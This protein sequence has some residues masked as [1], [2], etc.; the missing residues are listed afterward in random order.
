MFLSL[1]DGP[2]KPGCAFLFSHLRATRLAQLTLLDFLTLTMFGEDC[3][4]GGFSFLLVLLLPSEAQISS[5]ASSYVS[6]CSS[7][8]Q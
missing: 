5:T 4:L 2:I 1:S 8:L 7:S 6:L 3:K